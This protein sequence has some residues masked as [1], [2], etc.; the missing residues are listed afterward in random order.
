MTP[1]LI[2]QHWLQQLPT[3]QRWPEMGQVFARAASQP[4]R[5]WGLPVRVC[6]VVGGTSAQALPGAAALAC[7]QV[8]IILI[9]DLLD[10]D[11]RGEHHR[12]GPPLV[13][14]LAAALQAAGLEVVFRSDLP[15]TTQLC[16]V[17]CLNRMLADV[18]FGQN[19]D[20]LA[21]AEEAH[22][23]RVAALKSGAFFG[24]AW[25]VGAWLGG[26]TEA[27]VQPLRRVGEWYGEMIQIHDDLSDS[28]AV[29]ASPDW[30]PGRWT[31]P[32]LFAEVVDHPERERFRQLRSQVNDPAALAEAQDLL[33]RCGAISYGL[34]ELLVR[35]E[36]ARRVLQATSLPAGDQLTTLLNEVIE[37]V[38]E[39]LASASPESRDQ[40]QLLRLGDSRSAIVHP[41]AQVSGGK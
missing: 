15:S 6:E 31:L 14:N 16:V 34:H 2:I 3:F 33:I 17:H 40:A 21:R 24:A 9:D 26:A 10:A 37:P 19:L 5:D 29:P 8:S 18:A 1:E 4:Q 38:R 11:P 12:L 41:E 20:T 25:E 32:L 13:A 27:L 39:V 35:D 23:W 36:Q 22:Y 7:L 30:T 28:L